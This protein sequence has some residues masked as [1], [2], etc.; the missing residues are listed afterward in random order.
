MG[1]LGD[2]KGSKLRG[3]YKTSKQALK[4]AKSPTKIGLYSSKICN[5]QSTVTKA[6]AKNIGSNAFFG[7]ANGFNA[8]EQLRSFFKD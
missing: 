3:I 1:I 4:T 6:I 8:F 7:A 2:C 5:V